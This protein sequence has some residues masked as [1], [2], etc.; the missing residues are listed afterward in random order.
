MEFWSLTDVNSCSF[1]VQRRVV[2]RFSIVVN[3][4]EVAD[5]SAAI[6]DKLDEWI[7]VGTTFFASHNCLVIKVGRGNLFA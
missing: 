3:L 5:P 1:L 4:A 6:V 7:Y 2:V